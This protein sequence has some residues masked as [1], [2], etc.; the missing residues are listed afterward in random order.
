MRVAP[1]E[2]TGSCAAGLV[3]KGPRGSVESPL[4]TITLIL[5]MDSQGFR[6]RCPGTPASF[7]PATQ[8]DSLG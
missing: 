4:L 6:R 3:H 8:W 5:L 7:V 1:W 2:L